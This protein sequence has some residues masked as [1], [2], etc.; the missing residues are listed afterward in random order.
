MLLIDLLGYINSDTNTSA[1]DVRLTCLVFW[2]T[3]CG[4]CEANPTTRWRP[5]GERLTQMV[6][7]AKMKLYR[8]CPNERSSRLYTPGVRGK[9]E[10]EWRLLSLF[11]PVMMKSDNQSRRKRIK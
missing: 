5:M 4:T 1:G 10:G 11:S 7:G 6:L 8:S 3:R 9:G 2:V